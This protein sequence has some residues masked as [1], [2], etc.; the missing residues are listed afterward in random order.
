MGNQETKGVCLG[1][2]G[3]CLGKRFVVQCSDNQT[4]GLCSG[5]ESKEESVSATASRQETHNMLR[6]GDRG[7]RK[8]EN[9]L[10]L[11]TLATASTMPLTVR[12]R[13]TAPF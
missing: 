7:R 8:R 13:S 1:R 6:D 4:K 3:G 12:I 11:R 2:G 9:C 5:E 10:F